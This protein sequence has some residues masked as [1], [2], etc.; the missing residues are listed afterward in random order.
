MPLPK[1]WGFEESY[2]EKGQKIIF[3]RSIMRQENG[4]QVPVMEKSVTVDIDKALR[5]GV[6]SCTVNPEECELPQILENTTLLL[7]ILETFKNMNVC[8][9]LGP[10]NIHYLS[11]D[12]VFKDCVDRWRPNDCIL[13]SK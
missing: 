13:L 12:A 7:K 2:T 11:T 5:Y 9:G 6:H 3:S 1:S 8:S 10:V 4:V